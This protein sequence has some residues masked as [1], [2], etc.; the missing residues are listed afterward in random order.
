[1]T[2]V[3]NFKQDIIM[4]AEEH[5]EKKKVRNWRKKY[6]QNSRGKKARFHFQL[7]K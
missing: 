5:W 7:E 6:V 1:M 2:N 3:F 4:T